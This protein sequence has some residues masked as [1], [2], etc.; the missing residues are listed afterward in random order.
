MILRISAARPAGGVATA[1][2]FRVRFGGVQ[3]VAHLSTTRQGNCLSVTA[4]PGVLSK[5]QAVDAVTKTLTPS[6]KSDA[7]VI[8]TSKSLAVWLQDA[9]FVSKLLAPLGQS[10]KPAELS[11]LSAAVDA[12]P[13]L[14]S[15]GSYSSSE[16]LAILHG[17]LDETLPDLWSDPESSES[18]L[19]PSLEFQMAPLR[20]DPVQVTVPV[21]NTVFSNGRSHTIFASQWQ[22]IKGTPPKLLRVVERTRQV[23]VTNTSNSYADS[24]VVAPLVPVTE[25]RKILAGLGNIL[26]QIEIDLLP[27]PASKELEDIIPKL[28][29]ARSDRHN[30][31]RQVGPMGVWAMVYPERIVASRELPR[32]FDITSGEEW[33]HARE[34]SKL[35]FKLLARGCHVRKILSG[36]GGWGFKQGLLSLDPQTKYSTSDDEDVENFIRSFHGQDSGGA[37]IAPGS[38]VQYFV[39][40]FGCPPR[41]FRPRVR[42]GVASVVLGNQSIL[43]EK[44]AQSD[45]QV[46]KGQFGAVSSQGIYISSKEEKPHQITTKLDVWGSYITSRS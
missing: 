35:V 46:V 1:L 34:A 29:K 28:L 36:G 15:T 7:V 20:H 45:I 14:S 3:R 6:S 8:L 5:Q 11:V 2:R 44:T 21:A 24:R 9:T 25:P 18:E 31:Y 13:R 40:P 4:E 16:G 17:S 30:G 39:E 27:A 23:I 26:R 12:I 42:G 10:E 33:P 41:G 22:T 38:Y 43:P 19:Q 32:V 37:T